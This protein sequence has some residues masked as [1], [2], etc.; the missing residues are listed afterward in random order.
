VRKFL[1]R[2]GIVFLIVALSISV[3]TVYG[4][5]HYAV[6]ALAGAALGV[7]GFLLARVVHQR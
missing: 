5:Y 2:L 3:A 1:P 7:A 6:D 4:R